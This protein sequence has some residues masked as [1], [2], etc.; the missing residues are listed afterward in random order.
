[1]DILKMRKVFKNLSFS[2]PRVTKNSTSVP[3]NKKDVYD[4]QDFKSRMFIPS[5]STKYLSKQS[6]SCDPQ[7]SSY[8]FFVSVIICLERDQ[9]LFKCIRGRIQLNKEEMWK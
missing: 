3:N 5:K 9:V 7:C 2:I 8:K 6:D 1:M 4:I